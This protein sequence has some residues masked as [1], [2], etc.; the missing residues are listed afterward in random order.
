MR[1]VRDREGRARAD[2][3]G[4][5][6]GRG[7]YVCESTVCAAGLRDGRALSRSLRA[8]VTVDEET[9]DFIREWQRSESTK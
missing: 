4:H 2:P 7:A 1:F 6:E 9:L 8:T 5:R 3:N